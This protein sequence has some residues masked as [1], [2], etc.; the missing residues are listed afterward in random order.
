MRIYWPENCQNVR[1][2][3]ERRQIGGA[4]VGFA[5]DNEQVVI[6]GVLPKSL[7]EARA[8]LAE[9][10]E[11]G[12]KQGKETIET[13]KM[14]GIGKEI[15]IETNTNTKN[16]TGLQAL[17]PNSDTLLKTHKLS[18]L[19]SFDKKGPLFY[20]ENGKVLSPIDGDSCMVVQYTVPNTRRMHYLSID[21]SSNSKS[22]SDSKS[23]CSSS[24]CSSK[25]GMPI[26]IE[27]ETESNSNTEN[28]IETEIEKETEKEAKTKQLEALAA[29]HTDPP[30]SITETAPETAPKT[31][32]S[33][34][35]GKPRTTLDVCIAQMNSASELQSALEVI[36]TFPISSFEGK[37]TKSSSNPR[38]PRNLRNL[39]RLRNPRNSRGSKNLNSPRISESSEVSYSK[40]SELS[41]TSEM[42]EMSE[43]S[44]SSEISESSESSEEPHF[45]QNSRKRDELEKLEKIERYRKSI[46]PRGPCFLK[47]EASRRLAVR[48][49]MIYRLFL[50]IALKALNY[51]PLKAHCCAA[52]QIEMRI[53]QLYYLPL[54]YTRISIRSLKDSA[55]KTADRNHTYIQFYN[56]LLLAAVDYIL[57][58]YVCTKVLQ[59]A[60]FL[61]TVLRKDA[62]KLLLVELEDGAHWLMSYPAGFKLNTQLAEYLG[63][64][65]ILTISWWRQVVEAA[66]SPKVL[67]TLVTLVAYSGLVGGVSLQISFAVDI[68]AVSCIHVLLFYILLVRLYR[69]LLYAFGAL[70]RVF[71]GRKYNV[72]R[73]R[74]DRGDYDV[75]QLLLGTLLFTLALFL[76]P[77]IFAFYAVFAACRVLELS[78]LAFLCC[79]LAFINYLPL[80]PLIL[81]TVEPERVPG[82]IILKPTALAIGGYGVSLTS[83]PVPMKLL[84]KN[85]LRSTGSFLAR[86]FSTCTLLDLVKGRPMAVQQA[87]LYSSLYSVMPSKPGLDDSFEE[88]LRCFFF[89][90]DR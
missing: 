80:F 83:H 26:E 86:G 85:F 16:T 5:N 67:H 11:I 79:S 59:N 41:E 88:E 87:N 55:W 66:L 36:S 19:G 6:V 69:H 68:V 24:N 8:L 76:V 49:L 20:I 64:I 38:S 10:Y 78:V 37:K 62:V 75:N 47:S 29:Y 81:R 4:L 73:Q 3:G 32:R 63:E 23:S 15:K 52:L 1:L 21:E 39:R 46:S 28:K 12:E 31:V 71:R 72:L 44:E 45:V 61:E 43:M 53:N 57:G 65:I 25:I 89:S 35:R 17:A 56:V 60:A 77:T 48:A 22:D 14:T 40:T 34:K 70:F 18:V 27:I 2:D 51:S 82:G 90:T 13:E 7:E 54:Q 30:G 74:V 84:F 9:A 33:V 50:E 42:S 58:W